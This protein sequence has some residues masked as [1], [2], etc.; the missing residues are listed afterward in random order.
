M[1]RD[2]YYYDDYD[3]DYEDEGMSTGSKLIIIAMFIITVI[4]IILTLYFTG[5]IG[6]SLPERAADAK[7][8]ADGITEPSDTEIQA[9]IDVTKAA[10]IA[11]GTATPTDAQIVTA[12]EAVTKTVP[13]HKYPVGCNF[14]QS[15]EFGEM[16]CPP[17]FT[18]D[19][20]FGYNAIMDCDA[21]AN[22]CNRCWAIGEGYPE[23][24]PGFEEWPNR[25]WKVMGNRDSTGPVSSGGQTMGYVGG[26][27]ITEGLS[28]PSSGICS[29]PYNA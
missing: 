7:L 13:E 20:N 15:T 28:I 6:G 21:D 14:Q 8:I 19:Y 12:I 9:L 17:G 5:Y 1:S 26:L 22:N 16:L 18:T 2:R 10:L 27:Y 29:K 3:W 11:E 4:G 25:D 23:P 24:N